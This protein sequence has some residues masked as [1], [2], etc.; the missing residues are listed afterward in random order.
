MSTCDSALARIARRVA[1][2]LS[3]LTLI[4]ALCPAASAQQF[5]TT[6][7]VGGVSVD[8]S[9]VLNNALTD[10]VGELR[11]IRAEALGAIPD[12]LDRATELRKISLHRLDAA[13]RKAADAGEEMPDE[14][15]YLAGLQRIR[16]VLVYPKQRD[17]VLAGPA[18]GWKVDNRGSIVGSQSG[19]PMMLLEDLLTALRTANAPTRG[20]ISCSIDPTPEGIQRL[21]S[22]ARKLRTIGNPRATAT[23]IEQ[24]LGPQKISVHGVADTSHFARVMVAA[25]YRM[26]RVSMGLEPAPIRGLPSFVQM[27]RASG[28][29]M[30]NML[31]RWWLAPDYQPLLRDAEGLSWELPSAAVKAMAENDFFDAAGIA[32]R[33]GKADA[34]SQQWADNLTG[35]Y[36]E[37]AMADPIF[38]QLRNCMDLAVVAALI[39]KEDLAGK[40]G[41]S[42]GMLMDPNGLQAAKWNAPRQ[43]ASK[44]SLVKKGRNWVIACGGVQINPWAIVE[45]VQKSDALAPLRSNAAAGSSAN[46][47]WD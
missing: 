2:T 20:Q 38:G 45:K 4:A 22:H 6:R 13:V 24:Q 44:A 18:E 29:G 40:A 14:I 5:N 3:T 36:D 30:K 1:V 43:V 31:P 15:A 37:L 23:G 9:G 7:A 16:Y 25:D 39:V 17:I 35:R 28:R 19:R 11:R 27:M 47:W 21:G 12:P 46:W 8:T 34:V 26:K 42:L 32:H 33:T 10:D 41:C